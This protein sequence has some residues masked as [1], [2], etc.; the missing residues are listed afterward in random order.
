MFQKTVG[1]AYPAGL[2]GELAL[3]GPLRSQPAKLDSADADNNIVGRAFTVKSGG[4]GQPLAGDN[5]ANPHTLIVEAGGTGVFAGLLIHPKALSN[6]VLNADSLGAVPNGTIV[7][8]A[9]E[10]AG[11][12][13][14]VSAACDVG[15]LVYYLEADGAL[16]TAA[17]AANA[18]TGAAKTPIGRIERFDVAT[19]TGGLAVASLTAITRP[20]A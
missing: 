5:G 16:V 9:Q 8:L 3:H 4:T 1:A 6:P 19:P 14:A 17:P 20:S 15:D 12:N 10:A 7:D 11:V 13:V 18:P 2:I